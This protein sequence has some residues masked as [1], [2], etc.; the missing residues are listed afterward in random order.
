MLEQVL[1]V[2]TSES[3]VVRRVE[4]LAAAAA[5]LSTETHDE[6]VA[7]NRPVA[8]ELPFKVSIVR[9]A[10]KLQQVC[11][12]RAVAYSVRNSTFGALLV[13][14][15]P[16]DLEPGNVVLIAECKE[17]GQV[18]GSMRIHTNLFNPVPMETVIAM[19]KF[20]QGQLLAEACRFC[21]KQGENSSLVRLAL[22]K[23]SYLYCYSNQI[24]YFLCVAK[25]PLNRVYKSMGF[26]PIDGGDSDIWLP[27][28]YVANIE[29]SMLVMNIIDLWGDRAHKF[30]G[31][32][33]GTYHP[34]LV[35]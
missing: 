28:G 1:D 9:T 10:E 31:F 18:L 27:V 34:D 17:T 29:H 11:D 14:P 25:K 13:K 6:V 33:R 8:Q 26:K 4:S 32:F 20:M 3:D 24:E 35:I 5:L 22:F 12:L 2:V 7:R 23:T 19:P 16:S 30:Y 21:I 15:E